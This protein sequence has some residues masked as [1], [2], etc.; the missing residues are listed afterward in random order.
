MQFFQQID[1]GESFPMTEWPLHITVA[2]IFAIT[3][4]DDLMADLEGYINFQPYTNS[5]IKDEG[6]LG[7]TPVWLLQNT[8]E[9]Q[10]THDTLVGIVENHGAVFNTPAFTRSGFIPHITKQAHS[11]LKIGDKISLSTT[12]LVDFFPGENW[13]QRK[14]IKCFGHK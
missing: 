12:S 2:D 5:Y 14:V 13:Q 4:T 3:V 10:K 1:E 8:L 9:L 6:I 7:V 11:N